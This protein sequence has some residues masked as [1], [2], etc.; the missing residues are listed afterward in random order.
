MNKYKDKKII[1]TGGAGFIGSNLAVK[2]VELDAKVTIIDAM[3]KGQGG[4]LFNL[5]PIKKDVKFFKVELRNREKLK[6]IIKGQDICFNLAGSLSHVDSMIDPLKDLRI[7]CTSQLSFLEA[8]REVNP[9]IKVIYA[10]TRNQ[11]GKV[12]RLPVK[13]DHPIKPIDINGIHCQAA[14]EYHRLYFEAYKIPFCSL[15]MVNTFGPRHQ[16]KHHKQGVLNWFIRQLIDK[17][18]VKLYG[19]GNQLRDTNFVDDVIEALL[20]AGSSE[21]VW[22][23]VFNLGGM[24]ISLKD[25]VEA[26]IEVNGYGSFKEVEFPEERKFIEIG[27]YISDWS[28]FKIVTGWEPK[29]TL[30]QSI[31]ETT[32]YYTQHKKHYW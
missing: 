15:R 8:C 19:G 14:E 21:K 11:Y 30:H 24:G 7:N 26:F 2:L 32:E 4:N 27:D 29:S 10:G 16:M 31:K 17:E 22:G 23:K 18:E 3:L 25:F 20:I 28:Y 12:T 1:I 6:K 13:E 5:K 9:N